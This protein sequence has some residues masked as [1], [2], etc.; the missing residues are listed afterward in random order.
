MLLYGGR[1]GEH[2]VSLRSAAFVHRH[3]DRSRFELLPV[4]VTR[5]GEWYLQDRNTAPV[6]GVLGITEVPGRRLHIIPGVGFGGVDGLPARPLVFPV[7]HGLLGEDGTMQ[8]MLEQAGIP[9]VGADVLGSA[10]SM[11][12]DSVKRVW[13]D[14][15]LPVVPHVA[16][17]KERWMEEHFS[18]DQFVREELSS[19]SFPLFIKPSSAGS[20]LGAT[21]VESLRKMAGALSEAFGFSA[22]VVLEPWIDSRELE[23]S[24]IGNA[25]VKSFPVGEVVSE[26]TFYDYHAKYVDPEGA[27]LIVPAEI[28]PEM[29]ER[30]RRLAERAYLLA[31]V[32]GLARVDFFLDCQSGEIYINELNTLPGFTDISMFPRMC[33]NGGL[34]PERLLGELIELG[35]RRF[36]ERSRIIE[37]SIEDRAKR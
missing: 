33:L 4:G 1:S 20:S 3:I 19:I 15:G 5:R 12:K 32:C 16:L 28:D 29:D 10:L 36:E 17:S 6:D 21:K 2:D 9:Y 35:M 26:Y 24:V 30:V 27:R 37:S 22:K 7:V 18:L 8:G 11:D 31:G 25:T 14:A 23:C 13:R 34:S